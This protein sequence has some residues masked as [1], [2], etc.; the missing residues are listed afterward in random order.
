MTPAV[1]QQTSNQPNDANSATAQSTANEREEVLDPQDRI[2]QLEAELAA[3]R[4]VRPGQQTVSA[5]TEALPPIIPQVA[6]LLRLFEDDTTLSHF[7]N[8]L[9]IKEESGKKPSLPEIVPGFKANA[10]DLGRHHCLFFFFPS[11]SSST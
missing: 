4:A 3:L 7:K 1:P 8:A 11:P 2:A 9:A 10:L 6:P 5:E